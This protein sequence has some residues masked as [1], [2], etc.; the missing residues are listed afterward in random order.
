MIGWR[1]PS[2]A[3]E[4][5]RG[6]SLPSRRATRWGLGRCR[7]AGGDLTICPDGGTDSHGRA[8]L[9]AATHIQPQRRVQALRLSGTGRC[10]WEARAPPTQTRPCGAH[11]PRRR[12]PSRLAVELDSGPQPQALPRRAG[13]R[14]RLER[15]Q[16]WPA[17][18]SASSNTHSPPHSS[19]AAMA[20]SRLAARVDGAAVAA[21]NEPVRRRSLG[22]RRVRRRP[23]QWR[24]PCWRPLPSP[25]G[26]RP[27][28]APLTTAGPRRGA[29][30]RTPPR[31]RPRGSAR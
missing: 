15:A 14:W 19:A 18:A 26:A 31:R 5:P 16:A 25:D 30:V 12:S 3:Q 29:C 7:S 1:R 22:L 24:L 20:S 2:D 28:R 23:P 17:S 21:G 13:H 4:F 9:T 6:R 10:I 8:R 27:G 11:R